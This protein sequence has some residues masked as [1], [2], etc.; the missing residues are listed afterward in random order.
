MERL[1]HSRE[2]VE[3]EAGGYLGHRGGVA[4]YT[5]EVDTPVGDPEGTDVGA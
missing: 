5:V 2:A 4:V 3:V 1:V